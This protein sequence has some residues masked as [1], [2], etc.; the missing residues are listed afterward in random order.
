MHTLVPILNFSSLVRL[1]RY[2]QSPLYSE[3]Q[4][5]VARV[6]PVIGRDQRFHLVHNGSQL[7]HGGDDGILI[8]GRNLNR[9]FADF[10]HADDGVIER[11]ELLICAVL[12]AGKTLDNIKLR[13]A[14]NVIADGLLRGNAACKLRNV[15]GNSGENVALDHITCGERFDVDGLRVRLEDDVLSGLHLDLGVDLMLCKELHVLFVGVVRQCVYRGRQVRQAA[16]CSFRLPGVRIAVAVEDDALVLFDHALDE[17]V[18]CAVKIFLALKLVCK[19]L[20]LIGDD[21]VQH[22]VRAGDVELR[23]EA[24]ELELVAGESERGG[25][26]SVRCILCEGRQNV[27]ANLHVDAERTAIDRAGLNGVQ[28]SRKLVAEED[29]DD[30]RRRFVCAEAVVVA[31]GSDDTRQHP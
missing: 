2:V 12:Q 19:L 29:G 10:L 9:I 4:I 1:K 23:A 14:R 31:C 8:I 7:G 11:S 17:C 26:V 24:S 15:R 16:F 25:S 13:F 5:A 21:R 27:Y 18:E 30:G 20:E 3:H 28:N 22:D 6:R